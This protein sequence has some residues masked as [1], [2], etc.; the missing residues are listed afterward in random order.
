M[1]LLSIKVCESSKTPEDLDLQSLATHVTETLVFHIQQRVAG[2]PAGTL[3]LFLSAELGLIN[4]VSA[5]LQACV[6]LGETEDV[7]STPEE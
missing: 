4:C 6:R 3:S 2:K 1:F 7:Y 5:H